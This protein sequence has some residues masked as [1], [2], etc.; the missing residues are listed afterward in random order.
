[1]EAPGRR[2]PGCARRSAAGD[3]RLLPL[4]PDQSADGIGYM[5]SATFYRLARVVAARPAGFGGFD[6][7]AVDDPRRRAQRADAVIRLR[8]R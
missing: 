3:A 5:A 7:F 8:L 6:R 1:M 2:G 4:G